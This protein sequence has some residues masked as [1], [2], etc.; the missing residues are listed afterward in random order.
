MLDM[1]DVFEER[2][3]NMFYNIHVKLHTQRKLLSNTLF[4]CMPNVVVGDLFHPY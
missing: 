3:S 4:V 1:G 2:I